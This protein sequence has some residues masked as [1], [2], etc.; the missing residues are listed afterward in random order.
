M[1]RNARRH[2][3]SRLHAAR[4]RGQRLVR[5]AVVVEEAISAASGR[6]WAGFLDFAIALLRLLEL[7]QDRACEL[8]ASGAPK[9][10]Q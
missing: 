3:R 7:G 8:M 1:V 9:V 5:T 4:R 10:N 2:C 6:S